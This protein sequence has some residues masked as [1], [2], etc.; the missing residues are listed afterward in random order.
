MRC[1]PAQALQH[2]AIIIVQALVD[3]FPNVHVPLMD[4][5]SWR[6]WAIRLRCTHPLLLKSCN[7]SSDK[8]LK[9]QWSC[10]AASGSCM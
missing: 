1:S 4:Q 9:S 3:A 10:A 5:V 8:S 7:M 2:E 6:V